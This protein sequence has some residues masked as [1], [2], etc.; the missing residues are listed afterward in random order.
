MHFYNRGT[1]AFVYRNKFISGMSPNEKRITL[2]FTD[3]GIS[4]ANELGGWVYM[5]KAAAEGPF[6][7]YTDTKSK[8]A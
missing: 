2:N 1:G 4:I 6:E 5:K 7:I 3:S 8:I